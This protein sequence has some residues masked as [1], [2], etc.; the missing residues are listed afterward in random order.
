M[1]DWVWIALTVF[2]LFAAGGCL[3]LAI[4]AAQATFYGDIR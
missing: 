3:V 1:K 4:N 2:L